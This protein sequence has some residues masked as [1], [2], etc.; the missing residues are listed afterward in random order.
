M[1]HRNVDRFSW[2]FLAFGALALFSCAPPES[3]PDTGTGGAVGSGGSAPAGSGGAGTGGASSSGGSSTGG[4]S[5]GGSGT[6]GSAS[7]GSASGGRATGGSATGGSGSGGRSSGGGRGGSV[8]GSGGSPGGTGGSS[9]GPGGAMMSAG[10]GMTGAPTSNTY[11]IN[12]GGTNRTYI[13]KVPTPYDAN[14]AY[15]LIVAYHWLNGTAQNVSSENYYGL[16]NLSQGSTIFVAPQGIGNAWN[17]SGRTSTMGGQDINFTKALVTDLT[18]KFCIDKTR[19]FAEGFSM[20]GSMSYAAACA[21]GDVFRAVVAHSGGPMSGCVQHTKPVAYFMT[22]GTTD[23][24]CTYPGFG[25]PQVNDFGRVNGCGTQAMP[26]PSGSEHLCV[27]YPNCMSGYPT[28]ACIF[29]GG[30]TPSPPGNW[31]PMESWKFLSQF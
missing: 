22:H 28:R 17:D 26:M 15:K 29:V 10:C 24:V 23:N 11:T 2:G 13:L 1:S 4:S 16:W 31:V 21:M 3:T 19:I 27:D 8:M 9:G 7:G 14:K 5:T 18:N 30:H 12:V 25:V 20:G 6:G